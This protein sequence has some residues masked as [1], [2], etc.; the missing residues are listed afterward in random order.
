[1]EDTTAPA[2]LTLFRYWDEKRRGRRAPSRTDL[3]PEDILAIL[4]RV[5]LLDVVGDPARFR[6]RVAGTAWVQEFGREVTGKFVDEI[7]LG[8]HEAMILADYQRVL[9]EW[10][11][12]LNC[13]KFDL[14]NGR[15]VRYQRI[16][17]PLSRDGRCVDMII[18]AAVGFRSSE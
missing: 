11:P 3:F 15:P 2:L 16:L 10:G 8:A 14:P 18:G 9:A 12:V 17:L 13:W 6:F 7:G 5:I 1:M 4:P